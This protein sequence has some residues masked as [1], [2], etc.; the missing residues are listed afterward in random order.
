MVYFGEA[1]YVVVLG[2]VEDEHVFSNLSFVKSKLR[3][4]LTIRLNLIVWMCVQSFY[5][6]ESF[7]F[8]IAI[9]EAQL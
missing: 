9:C 1:M 5:N 2:S 6:L 3:N 8:Y 7:P 4:H